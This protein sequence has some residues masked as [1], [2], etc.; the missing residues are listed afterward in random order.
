MEKNYIRL[1]YNLTN[2]YTSYCINDMYSINVIYS[3]DIYTYSLKRGKL[4]DD[5]RY[6][7]NYTI[8]LFRGYLRGVQGFSRHISDSI[9][10]FLYARIFLTGTTYY[11][12]KW[13]S[14]EKDFKDICND[15]ERL[16]LK[17]YNALERFLKYSFDYGYRY[18]LQ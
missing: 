8:K 2:K 17:M 12:L 14:G 11:R 4:E 16:N 15:N 7:Y 9:H 5:I 1:M 18:G 6:D 10:S 3:D 13:L